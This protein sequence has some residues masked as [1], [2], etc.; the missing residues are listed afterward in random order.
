M[1]NKSCIMRISKYR[2]VLTNLKLL[3]FSKVF[4]DNL[5]DAAGETAVQ[6]RKD[7]S[8][9]A[10]PGNRRG[11]YLVDDLIEQLDKILGK[12]KP[13]KFIVVGIGN[14]G[15]ALI[16]Y[17][18]FAKNG[19]KI[20]AGFDNDPAKIAPTAEIP[21]L[22]VD[23]LKEFISGNSIPFAII[24]VPSL[25]APQI[26][27]ILISAGIKGILNFAPINIKERPGCLIENINLVTELENIIYFVNALEKTGS[28]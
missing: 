27:E 9:L 25:A 5:A 14:I 8:V 6:V 24:C 3:N 15:R 19:I 10:I 12:D 22:A 16:N 21:I 11:G 23:K 18:G 7:F 28:A 4:S 13:Q 26:V 17:A 2:N 1:H 20:M